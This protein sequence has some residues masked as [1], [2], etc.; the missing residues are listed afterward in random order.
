LSGVLACVAFWIVQ[1]LGFGRSYLRIELHEGGL[2]KAE[3]NDLASSY[4][5]WQ[6][7]IMGTWIALTLLI[8]GFVIWYGKRKGRA[9]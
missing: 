6:W 8:A 9:I 7:L 4:E 3:Y 2:T 5:F 1:Q